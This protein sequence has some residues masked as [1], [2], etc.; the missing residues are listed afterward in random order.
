LRLLPWRNVAVRHAVQSRTLAE[1]ILSALE[2]RGEGP[3][4]L[5]DRLP[6]ALLGVNAPGLLLECAVLTSPADRERVQQQAGLQDLA[7]TIADG[8]LAWQRNQ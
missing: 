3:T 1:A 7:A 2:L 8:V 5:R 6:C 4:R